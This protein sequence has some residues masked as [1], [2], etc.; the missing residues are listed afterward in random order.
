[1]LQH[2]PVEICG[3]HIGVN[4]SPGPWLLATAFPKSI[5][6][7]SALVCGNTHHLETS[8]SGLHVDGLSALTKSHFEGMLGMDILSKY[9]WFIDLDGRSRRRPKNIFCIAEVLPIEHRGIKVG[10]DFSEDVKTPLLTLSIGKSA[11]QRVVFDTGAQYSYLESLEGIEAKPAGSSTDF[12]ITTD[13]A[14]VFDVD[15]H[16]VTVTLG[17][18]TAPLTFATEPGKLTCPAPVG[19]LLKATGTDG[20]LGWEILKHGPMAYLPRR[21][22]L[23]I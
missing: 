10:L 13:G 11:R 23:W 1:M 3:N 15:L 21:G 7:V 8:Y 9:E 12:V 22:E 5:G 2:I 6:R 14:K 16:E 4:I 19:K 20:I 18:I 17:S